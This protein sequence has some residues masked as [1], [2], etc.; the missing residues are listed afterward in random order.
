MT[1]T[2][3]QRPVERVPVSERLRTTGTVLDA[4][5]AARRERITKIGRASCRE[6]V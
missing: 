5:L 3:S 2:S 6:R 1:T 4:I